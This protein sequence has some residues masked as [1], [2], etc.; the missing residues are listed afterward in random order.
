MILSYTLILPIS[1]LQTQQLM[2]SKIRSDIEYLIQT[3]NMFGLILYSK[4]MRNVAA[5]AVFY[6]FNDDLDS[7]LLFLGHSVDAPYTVSHKTE[8]TCMV[9]SSSKLNERICQLLYVKKQ[10][11]FK[12]IH[13]FSFYAPSFLLTLF[14][15]K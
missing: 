4:L 6:R 10:N 1:Q 7:G 14:A 12:I 13:V 9:R 11:G 5:L 2:T 8:P 3:Y 15:F